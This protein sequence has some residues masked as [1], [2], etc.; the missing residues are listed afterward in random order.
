VIT[1]WTL[2]AFGSLSRLPFFLGPFRESLDQAPALRQAIARVRPGASVLAT[3]AL[4]A[5]VAR[6]STIDLLSARSVRHLSGVDQVLLDASRGSWKASPALIRGLVHRLRTDP[7][8]SIR[9]QRDDVWLFD[10]RSPAASP[11]INE[12]R[13]Q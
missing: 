10:R 7:Q 9:Y 12:S 3:N 4:A 13:Q 5:H 1:G 6:R 8:W 2:L 11:T